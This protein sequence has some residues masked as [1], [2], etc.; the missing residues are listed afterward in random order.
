MPEIILCPNCGN[1]DFC[2]TPNGIL[3]KECNFLCDNSIIIAL[4]K[5]YKENQ[6]KIA[7]QQRKY[8]EG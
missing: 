5:N 1:N 2:L 4:Q 6:K 8:H 3:C 7:D